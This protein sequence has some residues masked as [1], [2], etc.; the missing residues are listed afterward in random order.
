MEALTCEESF[1]RKIVAALISTALLTTSAMASTKF[2]GWYKPGTGYSQF[3][4]DWRECERLAWM[5][6]P[7]GQRD[8]NDMMARKCMATKGYAKDPRGFSPK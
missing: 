6:G 5:Q 4:T 8:Y 3:K 2:V 1:M 7:H